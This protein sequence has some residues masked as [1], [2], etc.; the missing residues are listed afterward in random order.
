VFDT[1]IL[2]LADDD[3]EAKTLCV[4]FESVRELVNELERVATTVFVTLGVFNIISY[5]ILFFTIKYLLFVIS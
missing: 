1:D 5:L 4:D 2:V 3:D